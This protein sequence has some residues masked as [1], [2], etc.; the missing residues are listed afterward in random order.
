MFWV[1]LK[2]IFVPLCVIVLDL[3]QSVHASTDWDI[4]IFT[5]HWPITVC[6]QWKEAQEHHSCKILPENTWTIHGIWPTKVGTIGPLFCNH[7]LHFDPQK[8]EPIENNLLTYWPDIYNGSTTGLWKHEWN[9]HGTCAAILEPLDT[10]IKYFS[11]G[12][13]W[14]HMYT[15]ENILARAGINPDNMGYTP[16]QIWNAVKG[17]LGTNPDVQC[18]K[19]KIIQLVQWITL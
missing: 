13:E 15:M 16:Q 4:L 1:F 19:D 3:N 5:Q 14:I 12:L 6:M 10:E 8:L 7:S 2:L 18:V 9:K 17:S 11:K